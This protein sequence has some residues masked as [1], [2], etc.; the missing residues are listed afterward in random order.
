[1]TASGFE[2]PRLAVLVSRSD[3]PCG[4]E[5]FARLLASTAGHRATTPTLDLDLAALGKALDDTDAVVLNLPLVAWK[6]R[7][8]EPAVALA[9]A[10]AKGRGAIVVLHEWAD[11]DW[12]RRAAFALPLKLADVILFSCLEVSDQFAAS[13]LSRW[14]TQ[15][16]GIIPIPPNLMRPETIRAS[17]DSR[18]LAAER[19]KGRLILGHFGSIY[20][21]KHSAEVLDIVAA[22]RRLG[23]DPFVVFAGS[24]VKG[25]DRVQETF[26]ARVRALDLADRVRVTGFVAEPEDLFGIFEAVDVFVYRFAE[27]LTTRRASVQA[28]LTSGKPVVVNSPPDRRSVDAFPA[29]RAAIAT[30]QLC[31]ASP[32]ADV[33]ELAALAIRAAGS[34]IAVPPVDTQAAWAAALSALDAAVMR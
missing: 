13:P 30:G 11:L 27:G 20:P 10:H 34:R 26:E 22:I 4:V 5:A 2:A 23:R 25:Q 8:V 6:T 16:R 31:L 14:V 18:Y 15:R 17:D 32:H 12:K 21:K 7:L 24:F 33:D 9:M 3:A 1:M 28:C 19:A 29:Y